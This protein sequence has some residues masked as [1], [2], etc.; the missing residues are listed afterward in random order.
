M[1]TEVNNQCLSIQ[2]NGDP[3]ERAKI[4]VRNCG[5]NAWQFWRLP[6]PS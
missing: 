2:N 5:P 3:S 6:N 4:N 1:R